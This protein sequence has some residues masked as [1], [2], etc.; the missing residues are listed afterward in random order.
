MA[1]LLAGERVVHGVGRLLL[2]GVFGDVVGAWFVVRGGIW[3]VGG[4]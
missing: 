4:A 1:I 3:S 2:K